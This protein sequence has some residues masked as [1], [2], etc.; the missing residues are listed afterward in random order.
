M[1]WKWLISIGDEVEGDFFPETPYII[2]LKFCYRQYLEV[3]S[4]G[5]MCPHLYL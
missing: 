5:E 2:L 1:G 4:C 3:M